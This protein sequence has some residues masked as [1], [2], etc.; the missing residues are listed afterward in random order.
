MASRSYARY[1]K[2][3]NM[4]NSEATTSALGPAQIPPPVSNVNVKPRPLSLDISKAISLSQETLVS[5]SDRA[6]AV[7]ILLADLSTLDRSD[8]TA[9]LPLLTAIKL[10][11]RVTQGSQQ[12]AQEETLRCLLQHALVLPAPVVMPKELS[13]SAAEAWRVLCNA[14]KLHEQVAG[15]V[16]EGID[17]ALEGILLFVHVSL[18][19]CLYIV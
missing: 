5:V 17:S 13:T 18:S 1:M 19:I 4:A 8:I 12:L 6:W 2:T 10:F 7:S 9:T 3:H 16:I 14:V 11:G 15:K